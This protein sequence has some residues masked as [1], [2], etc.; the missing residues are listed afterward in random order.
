[1]TAWASFSGVFIAETYSRDAFSFAVQGI[2]QDIVNL[3]VVVPVLI[4]SAL[5]SARG[6]RGALF[7]WSGCLFYI[8]YSYA[9]YAFAVNFNSLFL[10]YCLTL[11][12]SFYLYFH[13]I[14]I[15]R[16][17]SPKGSISRGIRRLSGGFL[18][19]IAVIFYFLWLSDI[20]PAIINGRVPADIIESGLLSNPVHVMDLAFCLP[21]LILS[22]L[23]I[24][25]DRGTG[26][27]IAPSLLMFAV[28]MA[29]AIGGMVIAMMLNDVAVDAALAVIFSII[30]AVGM[31]IFIFLL[32]AMGREA[33][34]R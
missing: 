34:V 18:I 26:Y 13:F 16:D 8:A 24:L 17:Y 7:V 1:M 6:K 27:L 21:G 9:I 19:F 33:S 20:I 5:L 15:N 30:A 2:G 29:L 12:L 23:L 4:I 31:L 14:L 22:G 25:K 28:L 32:R 10:V 3:F 11:G